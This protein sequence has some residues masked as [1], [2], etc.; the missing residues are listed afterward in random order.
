MTPQLTAPRKSAIDITPAA[1]ALVLSDRL[2]T[3][4]REAGRAGLQTT[5]DRLVMLAHCVFDEPHIGH[6]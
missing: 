4:A 1:S 3:L 6:A 5:A 2:L